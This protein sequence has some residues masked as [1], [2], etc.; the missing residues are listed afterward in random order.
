MNGVSDSLGVRGVLLWGGTHAESSKVICGGGQVMGGGGTL[1]G[2]SGD[3]FIS[4]DSSAGALILV[5]KDNY[6]YWGDDYTEHM[7][8]YLYIWIIHI[9][10]PLAIS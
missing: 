7:A 6:S 3:N 10:Y 9:I 2:V 8:A 4:L 5:R 1:G